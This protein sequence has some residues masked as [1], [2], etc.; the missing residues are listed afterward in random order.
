MAQAVGTMLGMFWMKI[1]KDT[2]RSFVVAGFIHV[3]IL[4]I[5]TVVLSRLSTM[6]FIVIMS[7]SSFFTG[8]MEA[9]ILPLFAAASDY[10]VWKSGAR[11]DGLN[12]SAYSV[13]LR[14][15]TTLSTTIRVAILAGV[16][17][18]A[19]A[20]DAGEAVPKAVLTQLGNFHTLYP[21]ILAIICVGLVA[22]LY[23]ISDKKLK[24]IKDDL[25][26]RRRAEEAADA[27][28]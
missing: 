4:G 27:G 26:D 14:V 16:G 10:G 28:R 9:Y 8:L 15:G 6:Q 17:Y 22:L 7:A 11:A 19:K 25:A 18:N 23:P 20:Y 1:F 24:E 13:A 5:A 21:F 12:M 2:K 3:A